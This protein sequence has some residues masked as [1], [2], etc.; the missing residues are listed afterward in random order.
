[1]A[2]ITEEQAK[3]IHD[4]ID[5]AGPA[6]LEVLAR[7]CRECDVYNADDL[8]HEEADRVVSALMADVPA[9]APPY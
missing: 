6:R 4:G 3:L 8:T 7:V 5:P 9:D 1:V 2:K